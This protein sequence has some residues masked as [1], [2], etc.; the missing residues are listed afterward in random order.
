M[1]LIE[2]IKNFVY[3]IIVRNQL[4]Y[5]LV[6]IITFMTRTLGIVGDKSNHML[7][8][9]AGKSYKVCKVNGKVYPAFGEARLSTVKDITIRDDDVMLCGYPKTGCHWVHEIMYMLV[10]NHSQLSQHGKGIS[11]GGMIDMAADIILDSSSSPRVLN[12]HFLYE[13]LP[14]GIREKKTKIVLTVRNPKDTAVSFFNHVKNLKTF[15]D[16]DG[17]FDDFFEMFI[18]GDCEYGSYF[19][20]YLSWDELLK[21]PKKHDVLLLQFEENKANPVEGVKKIA[22]FLEL[23]ITDEYAAQVAESTDFGKMK[24]KRENTLGQE[25][26]RKGKVGDWR[27]W[28]SDAQ[29]GAIDKVWKA[30]MEGCTYQPDLN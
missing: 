14:T 20:Y 30:R 21:D 24:K 18:D 22:K 19:D 23:D 11:G 16:Y 26:F 12:S 28:L 1:G 17:E 15:Y 29:S 2:A 5:Y 13:D 8:D 3:G 6:P 7:T 4:V 10:N 25:M 9:R 27:N